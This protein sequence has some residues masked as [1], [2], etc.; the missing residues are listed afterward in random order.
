MSKPRLLLI[1]SSNGVRP[2]ANHGQRRRSFR[3]LV[4][5]GGAR[6]RS[7]PE[8]NSWESALKLI[9]LGFLACQLNYLA[10]LQATLAVLEAKTWA[11]SEKTS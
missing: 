9:D 5:L 7:A 1:H 4:I 2:R 11:D 6:A 10:F 8:Q 3:P